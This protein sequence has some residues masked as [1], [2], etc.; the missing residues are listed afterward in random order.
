MSHQKIYEYILDRGLKNKNEIYGFEIKREGVRQYFVRDMFGKVSGNEKTALRYLRKQDKVLDIGAGAGR[1]S[2]FLQAR[3]YDVT[4]LDKS[5]AVCKILKKRGVKKIVLK[6]FFNYSAECK[7]DAALMINCYSLFGKS[8]CRIANILFRL[9]K[10][11]IKKNG[12]AIFALD[13]AND[14]QGRIVSRRF[15][16]GNRRGRWFA[17]WHPRLKELI[18]IAEKNG[19]KTTKYIDSRN[20]YILILKNVGHE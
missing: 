12:L 1:I 14:C 10:Y 16:C 5:P 17:S 7:F 13:S 4:A 19:W 15:L 8:K 6:N 18:H 11:I 20:F 9:K 3:Q 2:V